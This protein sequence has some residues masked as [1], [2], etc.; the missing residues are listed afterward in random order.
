MIPFQQ[1]AHA[2][3]KDQP[4]LL[5]IEQSSGGRPWQITPT[6]CKARV[7]RTVREEIYAGKVP[8]TKQGQ[9]DLTECIPTD[10]PAKFEVELVVETE[11][12]RYISVDQ[13]IEIVD[14]IIMQE[15]AHDVAV[16]NMRSR[17]R[18]GTEDW[19][20]SADLQ[21]TLNLVE[22]LV[23]H[24]PNPGMTGIPEQHYQLRE[25]AK[26]ALEA[27]NRHHDDIHLDSEE[28]E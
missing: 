8:I 21:A 14:D 4:I 5:T 3:T 20:A 22:E 2:V 12:G 24:L 25:R 28:D 10:K 11:K 15:Q 27:H 26:A 23:D 9:I 7:V 19:F 1:P 13:K 18:A 16:E 6:E 17:A